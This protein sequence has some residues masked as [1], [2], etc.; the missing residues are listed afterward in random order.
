[1]PPRFALSPSVARKAPEMGCLARKGE[2]R[3]LNAHHGF[4]GKLQIT[5]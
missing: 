3:R 2:V 4:G 1:L 5:A